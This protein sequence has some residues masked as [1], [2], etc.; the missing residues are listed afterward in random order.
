MNTMPPINRSISAKRLPHTR[1][2]G[3]AIWR[4]LDRTLPTLAAGRLKIMLPNGRTIER[5]GA[6][7]GPEAALIMHRWRAIRRILLGGENGFTDSYMDGDW[8]TPDLP[9]LL[10]LCMRNEAQLT[11]AAHTSPAGVAVARVLH[12]LRSNTRRGSQRNIA[13]HYDLGNDFFAAWLDADM[14]YSSALYTAGG[15][16]LEQAQERKLDRIAT[17][18]ALAGGESVLEIGCGWGSLAER[19]IRSHSAS[20]VG[21][22]LSAA[23]F[24]YAEAR[25]VGEAKADLQL[26]DYRDLSGSFDRIVSVEMIEAVGESYWPVYF[27]KLRE[28]LKRG[29]IA[30]VQAI[31][32]DESRFPAYRQRPDFI[33]RHIFPGGM[34]PTKAIIGREAARVGL[35]LESHQGFG[36]SYAATLREWRS[37]FL[38]NW[39]GIKLMGFD[40]RFRRLWDYY[41]VYC[42]TGFRMR[43]VDV[44]LFKFIG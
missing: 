44:G 14:N 10:E 30:V 12:L 43:A 2:V 27:A 21:I 33:Q 22:T 18:L 1:E 24:A 9:R 16:T 23:Q 4:L 42:E 25:L 38:Q 36:D 31:T 28:C 32:I 7:D 17:L 35:R 34:L 39:P 29:G 5:R 13:A 20:V 3:G 11:A 40:E 41:L 19:L 8:S 37:R 6:A 26:L 15:D